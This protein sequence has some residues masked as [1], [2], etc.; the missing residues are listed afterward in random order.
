MKK[1]KKTIVL[2]MVVLSLMSALTFSVFSAGNVQIQLSTLVREVTTE[3]LRADLFGV[4][5]KIIHLFGAKTRAH[6]EVL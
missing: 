2:G 3:V 6:Q 4:R 1:L 5:R